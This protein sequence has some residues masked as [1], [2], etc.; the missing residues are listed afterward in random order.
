MLNQ[1]HIISIDTELLNWTVAEKL[2]GLVRTKGDEGQSSKL[3]LSAP[4]QKLLTRQFLISDLLSTI[5]TRLII[6]EN[7]EEDY[8]SS[9]VDAARTVEV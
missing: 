2:V 8:N 1:A 5:Y 4:A 6:M 9:L 7:N 3:P